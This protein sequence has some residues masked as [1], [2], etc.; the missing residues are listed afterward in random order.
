V[1][2]ECG[3]LAGA[4]KALH[5]IAQSTAPPMTRFDA[6][7]TYARIQADYAPS[8]S[9]AFAALEEAES[10]LGAPMILV[11]FRPPLPLASTPS[12]R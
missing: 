5:D 10:S 8:A 9:T 12:S 2:A 1:Q 3:D 11:M 6:Y 4:S 7:Y